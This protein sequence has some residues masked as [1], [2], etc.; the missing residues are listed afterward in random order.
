MKFLVDMPLS[1]RV[2]EWLCEQGHNAVHASAT[3][4]SKASDKEILN[5]ARSEERL[6]ISADL[7][8]SRLF[9][10]SNKPQPGLI[11]LRGGSYSEEETRVLISRVLTLV[12]ER[13][14]ENAIVVIDRYRIRRLQ[15]PLE[16]E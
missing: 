3:G 15:L 10:L 12:P 4:L 1:P 9:A 2:A 16:S 6:I 13:N 14:M 11:L 5:Q 8:F 7:D